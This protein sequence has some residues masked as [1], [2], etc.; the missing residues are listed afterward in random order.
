MHQTNVIVTPYSTLIQKT[1]TISTDKYILLYVTICY[2]MSQNNRIYHHEVQTFSYYCA[3]NQLSIIN[4][5]DQY[6]RLN[7][8]RSL[9]IYIKSSPN[10]EFC[11]ISIHHYVQ[12]AENIGFDSWIALIGH[13]FHYWCPDQP[14]PFIVSALS[15]SF[16]IYC[17]G[18][19]SKWCRPC[20][21]WVKTLRVF[22][23]CS[24]HQISKGF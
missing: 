9:L 6:W 11:P 24:K 20:V 7:Y 4:H 1:V 3:I 17:C 21:A 23:I 16:G 12:H 18:A 8:H 22:C 19:N 2:T 10:N 5:S 15:H 14:H 13:Q